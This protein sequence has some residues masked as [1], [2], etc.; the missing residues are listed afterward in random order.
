ML[1]KSKK[2]LIVDDD[3]INNIICKKIINEYNAAIKVTTVTNGKNALELLQNSGNTSCVQLPDV[4]LLDINMPVM[5]G[6]QFVDEYRKLGPELR[7][8]ITLFM[9]SSSQYYQDQE[10]VSQY[11]EV[12]GLFTKPLSTSIMNK[13][14]SVCF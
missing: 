7:K 8:N 4:I 6:W 10:T 1:T 9:L 2:I 11:Q 3:E 12:E 14:E 13:I 5:N